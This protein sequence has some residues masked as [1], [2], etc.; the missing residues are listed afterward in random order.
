MPIIICVGLW[1]AS[2]LLC[3]QMLARKGYDPLMGVLF[4]TLLGPF[5]LIFCFML[6]T[7]TAANCDRFEEQKNLERGERL[8]NCPSCGRKCG[9]MATFCARC[10]H[11][12]GL[13][14]DRRELREFYAD[15][16]IRHRVHYAFAHVFLPAYIHENPFAFLYGFRQDIPGGASDPT[17]FIQSRWCGFEEKEGL[18]ERPSDPF[19]MVFR[20]VSDLTMSIEE[21]AG[22]PVALVQMPTPERPVEAFF[23]AVVLLAQTAPVEDWP[24]DVRARVFTLEANFPENAGR[25]RAGVICEWTNEGVHHNLRLCI[26]A[27]RDAFLQAVAAVLQA[28]GAPAG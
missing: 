3:G 19:R 17:R 21:V 14:E 7:R 6:P 8:K 24:S 23:V 9:G 26:E 25:G 10:N 4:P 28:P 2:G 27:E 18:I 11:R 22:R 13:M 5:G 12:F 15:P 16:E 20:R 1:I